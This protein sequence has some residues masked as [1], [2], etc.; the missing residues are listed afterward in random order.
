MSPTQLLSIMGTSPLVE[1]IGVQ[2]GNQVY[3]H[4]KGVDTYDVES[5][6]TPMSEFTKFLMSNG[7]DHETIDW[8][9]CEGCYGEGFVTLDEKY[10]E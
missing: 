6:F 7:V 2:N 5:C 3:F 10:E 9:D 1:D 4:L 8:N